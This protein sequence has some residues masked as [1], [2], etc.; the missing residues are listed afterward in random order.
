MEELKVIGVESGSLL[1]ASEEGTRYRV[2]IDDVLQSRLRQTS[3]DPGA[4]RKLS[5]R[6]IQAHIRAGMSAED[7]AAITGV[8]LDYVQRFE[9]PVLAEREFVIE[10]ALAVP[11][12][13]ALETD[14]LGGGVTFGTVIRRRLADGGAIGE[15]WASWKEE[16]GGWVVKLTFVAETVEHDARWSFDPKKSTLAPLNQEAIAL[17][18]QGEQ[19]ANLVPRLRA[20]PLDEQTD[21]TRF[22]SGA[23]SVTTSPD[24]TG[25]LLEPVPYGRVGDVEPL[26][27]KKN[28]TADLLEALRK[29]RGE[30]DPMDPDPEESIAAHPSTGTVRLIDVPLDAMDDDRPIDSMRTKPSARDSGSFGKRGSKGRQSM[31]SWDEIVF[32]AR[33][34]DDL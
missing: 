1:V 17:S 33:T 15:R 10:S 9:G 27:V 25:P 18:Q 34:D 26:P 28:Q 6:E 5:P 22:D 31:P 14:P 24:E 12:Q 11:V 32:G 20:V 29:R 13:L 2:A 8:P 30:R 19:P 16:G 4:V 3:P 7:V 23:F 21:S